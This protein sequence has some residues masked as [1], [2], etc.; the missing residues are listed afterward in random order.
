MF[1]INTCIIILIVLIAITIISQSNENFGVYN[2]YPRSLNWKPQY[3][4]L[5]P[6]YWNFG[7]WGYPS[8][9]DPKFSVP[10][11]TNRVLF[12]PQNNCH[13]KCRDKYDYVIDNHEHLYKVK[14]CIKEYCY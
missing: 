4:Y 7:W 3:S 8:V 2:Y 9:Y 11:H 10:F 14:K 12:N 1:N 5:H 6:Y 13:E